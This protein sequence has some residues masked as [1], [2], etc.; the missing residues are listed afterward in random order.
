MGTAV[1]IKILLPVAIGAGL[2]IAYVDS[3]PRWD[4]AGITAL[5][6]IASCGILGA[7]SPGRPWLWALAV[8]AWLPLYY[9]ATTRNFG[10]LVALG[11]A[12]VGAYAGMGLRRA[13]KGFLAGHHLDR[14]P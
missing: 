8:G 12:F 11:F 13:S 7:L 4:D 14:A 6:I 2:L 1:M 9:I 5:A 10:S 3:R